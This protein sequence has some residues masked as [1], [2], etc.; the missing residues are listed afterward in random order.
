MKILTSDI[1]KCIDESVLCWLATVDQE[2]MPNVS[3]KE[4][5]NRCRDK[6][7]IANIASPNSINNIRYNKK[8]CL[9]FIEVFIQKG[10]Q[11]KG[12]A[13]VIPKGSADFP[14]YESILLNMTEGKFPFISIT[15]ITPL[16]AKSIVAP[17]YLFYPETTEL[18]Q[19]QSALRAYRIN[20]SKI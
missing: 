7:I 3:P 6:I 10:Y 13:K 17:K 8:V 16:H 19:I 2:G 18:E 4:I 5:F 14:E 9:S 11:I 12:W 1:I 20:S 15:E